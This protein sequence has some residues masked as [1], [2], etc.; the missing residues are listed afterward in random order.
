MKNTHA[1]TPARLLQNCLIALCVTFCLSGIAC[2]APNE[3]SSDSMPARNTAGITDAGIARERVTGTRGGS[4]G[5]RF[6]SPPK[7]FNYLLAEDEATLVASFYLIGGRLVE[8]DHDALRY[9]PALAES[10]RMADNGRTLDLTLRDGVRFSDGQPVTAEDVLFT[11]RAIYDERTASP[12]FASALMVGGKRITASAIDA[13]QVRFTFPEAVASPESY[14]ANIAVLPRHALAAD[15]D[16]GAL[17]NAYNVTTPPREIV[18]AGAFTVQESV[19]GERITFARNPHYWKRDAA[20]VQ[21]PY[22]DAL[23]VEVIPDANAAAARLNS[24]GIDIL[25]R[26]RPSDFAALKTSGSNNAPV[27]AYDLGAGLN[28]DYFWFNLNSSTRNAQAPINP[29]KLAWFTDAR[30]RR[31]VSL[32]VDRAGIA[33]S[34]SQGLA[35]PLNGIV[36]PGNQAWVAGDLPPLRYDLEQAR[37]LLREAGF[38]SRVTN[39]AAELYDSRGN[40]VEWTIIAPVENAARVEMATAIQ[41]DLAQL[42]MKVTVAP[43]EFAE[44]TRRWS[45][46]YDY[47]AVLLGASVTEP[48]PSSYANLLLSSSPGHQW[49]PNQP[50]PATGWERRIDGLMNL[51]AREANMDTRRQLFQDVQRIIAGQLP[52]IPIVARHIT[53]GANARV[54]NYRPARMLPFSLWNA[55]ELFVRDR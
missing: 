22:L 6:T 53:V 30:F 25:D 19:P 15:F 46:S 49:H 20:N 28:T 21:L 48:D 32:A 36:S 4:I 16:N 5:Y 3:T 54:G 27:R 11:L 2:R 40:R 34:V 44:L 1:P 43:V 29:A 24:G 7:T 17:R 45:K 37:T 33:A 31:A 50:T 38:A 8:F 12:A 39:D 47:D 23:V 26:L 52:V 35:T 10:W 42:G 14:L 13:R 51:Q 55:E 18:T 41:E 9:A